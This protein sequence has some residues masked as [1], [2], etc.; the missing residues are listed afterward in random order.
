MPRY[1]VLQPDG[2]I[3]VWSTI[4]DT[5]VGLD[6]SVD[7]ATGIMM[8]WFDNEER[9]NVHG[10]VTRCAAGEKVFDWW[11]DWAKCLAWATYLHGV[12]DDTIKWA[13]ERTPDAMTRRY[14]EQF[15]RTCKAES[16]ADE[17]EAELAAIVQQLIEQGKD[18]APDPNWEQTLDNL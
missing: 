1:P 11:D 13:T 4:V 17:A 9:A 14:I 18:A 8:Q 16:R 5:F 6:C 10:I 2:R 12:E 7:E 15:V 3:A